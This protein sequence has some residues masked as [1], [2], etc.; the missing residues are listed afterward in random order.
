MD[1]L[2]LFGALRADVM[3]EVSLLTLENKYSGGNGSNSSLKEVAAIILLRRDG[4]ALMQL[5]DNKPGLPLAGQWTPPGGHC[6]AGEAI[7][8][9]ARRE[10]LEETGYCCA[11]LKKFT[12]VSR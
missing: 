7:E 6:D 10:L 11:D 8:D 5:R 1:F 9:C 3:T 12:F 2:Q 4:A